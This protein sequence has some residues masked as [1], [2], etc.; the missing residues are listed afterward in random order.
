MS[1]GRLSLLIAVGLL[2]MLAGQQTSWAE[3]V[4]IRI[5]YPSGMN[6]QVP[7]V[8]DK[9]GIAAKHHLIAEFTSFQYGP[10]MMEGLVSDKLDAVCLPSLFHRR[11]QD[12]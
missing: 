1:L 11:C 12:R 6:G 10:P 4:K 5:G 3:D 7:V 9:A 8:L 2:G